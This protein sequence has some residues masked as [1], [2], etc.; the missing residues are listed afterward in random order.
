LHDEG[1]TEGL[2]EGLIVSSVSGRPIWFAN[3]ISM[4]VDWRNL[5]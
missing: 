1:S 2:I 3:C 5:C 4:G